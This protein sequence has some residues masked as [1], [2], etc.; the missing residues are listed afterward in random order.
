MNIR[1]SSASYWTLHHG[2]AVISFSPLG[3]TF[4]ALWVEKEVKRAN[5]NLLLVNGVIAVLVIATVAGNW[6]YC[7]NF[8]MGCEPISATELAVMK[9]PDQRWHNFVHVTGGQAAKSGYR[10][11]VKHM[12]N[13]QVISTEIKDE[14]IF[15]RVAEKLL[16]VKAP[17]GTTQLEYSGELEP[18]AEP[19]NNSLLTPLA[20][21][22]PDLKAQVLPFTLNATDYR[23]TGY[24]ILIV[25]VPF[26]L[27]AAWNLLKVARRSSEPQLAPTW[28]NLG[29]FGNAEQ[30][31]S[32]IE[33][34]LGP[35]GPRSYGKLLM[36]QQWLVRRKLYS[37]WVSPVAD[38]A[39]VYK[40]VTKHSVNFIPTGKTYSVILIGRHRQRTEE[41]MKEKAVNN[42]LNDL[43]LR[44]PW[45]FFGFNQTLESMWRKD[46]AGFIATIESRQQEFKAK[47]K[48]AAATVADPIT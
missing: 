8:I 1:N 37:T 12:Q 16:L 48:A 45:A 23:D 9:S 27:L 6:R 46:P 47:S 15:L 11:I 5:R 10:D 40:K 13:G 17:A 41:Q 30:L 7:A 33:A 19:I 3:E 42:L 26:F 25:G 38:L 21:Q 28:K 36:S 24:A 31:S 34:E 20:A 18:T 35:G 43:A 4:M 14:Y 29:Q 2:S 22:D 32:Q 44:V 39:W